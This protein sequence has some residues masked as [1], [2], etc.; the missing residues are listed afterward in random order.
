LGVRR[1]LRGYEDGQGKNN[2][3]SKPSIEGVS[4]HRGV[5]YEGF[6]SL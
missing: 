1:R 4:S 5:S 3:Q 6:A 2:R